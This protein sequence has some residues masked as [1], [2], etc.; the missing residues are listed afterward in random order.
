MVYAQPS[1]QRAWA[2]S[3]GAHASALELAG[4]IEYQGN[5]SYCYADAAA[6]FVSGNGEQGISAGLIEV[7]SGISVLGAHRLSEPQCE[8]LYLSVIPQPDHLTSALNLLGLEC[9]AQS[10]PDDADPVAVLRESLASGPVLL[11]P[12]DMGYMTYFPYHQHAAGADHYTVAYAMDDERVYLHD[13]MGLPAVS[14]T[15]EELTLAWRAEALP[16]RIGSYHRW[17]RLRRREHPTPEEIHRAAMARFEQIRQELSPCGD[18]I[19]TYSD[20]LRND[21]LPPRSHAFLTVFTFPTQSRRSLDYASFFRLSGDVE[22]ARLKLRQAELSSRCLQLGNQGDW[23][24][25]A[26]VLRE[27]ADLEDE[28]EQHRFA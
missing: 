8:K 11:G 3:D 5:I 16:S 21:T 23:H 24:A 14:L 19:R 10:E 7:L 25:V 26:D 22:A 27:M 28:L 18:V 2:R 6:M 15:F 1:S 20:E 9:E 12:I 13:P 4:A 17:F